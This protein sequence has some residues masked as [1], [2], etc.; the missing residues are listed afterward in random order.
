[1]V[2]RSVGGGGGNGAFAESVQATIAPQLG[3]DIPT[4]TGSIQVTVG[5]RGGAAG[6]AGAVDIDNS[7]AVAT[8]G[9]ESHGIFAQS[10]GGGGGNG[11][12]A[13]APL[14]PTTIG[15]SSFTINYGVTTGG[16]G[17]SGEMAA[18]SR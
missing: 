3:P 7:G 15:A 2:G 4:G 5:G 12:V 10:T 14:R 16:E 8:A 1:M 13:A 11:G 18:R 17:S 9:H 6:N